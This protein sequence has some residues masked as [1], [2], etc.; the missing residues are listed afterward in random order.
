MDADA[1]AQI[2]NVPQPAA[3]HAGNGV[4]H[5]LKSA[6]WSNGTLHVAVVALSIF[7]IIYLAAYVRSS[8]LSSPTVLDY[9]PWWFFRQAQRIVENGMVMPPWDEQSFFPPGRPSDFFN[10]WA[11]HMAIMY[12]VANAING[13]DLTT[14][15]KW[16]PMIVAAAA[17]IPAFLLGKLIK[18]DLQG[19]VT[20]LFVVLSPGLI[21]VSMA[22]YC[23]TD[24]IVAFYTMA[25]TFSLLLAISKKPDVKS[26]PYFLLAIIINLIFVFTWGYGWIIQMFFILLVPGLAMFRVVEQA[27]HNRSL[28]FDFKSIYDEAVSIAIP[29]AIVLIPVNVIGTLLNLQNVFATILNG[30]TFF[31]GNALIVNISVAEL[32]I[33]NPFSLEGITTIAERIGLQAVTLLAFAAMFGYIVIRKMLKSEKISMVEIYLF[34][35]IFIT[36]VL[37]TRGVRF[38]LLFGSAAA[39]T[40]GY[41]AGNLPGMLGNKV[42][43]ATFFGF[44]ILV[45]VMLVSTAISTGSQGSGMMISQ[46]WY[47]MLDWFKANAS[48]KSLLVTWWDPGHILTGYTGLRAM[49]DGAHCPS[50]V[51]GCEPYS[52]NDRIQ[53]MGRAFSVSDEN[54][55]VSILRKYRQLTSAQCEAD[56]QL[57]SGRGFPA[58]ACD[59]VSDMYVIASS[60]LIG[61]YYWL[62]YFGTGTGRNFLQLGLSNYDSAQGILT[63]GSGEISLVF[64]DNKWVPVIN[65]PTQGIRNV[66]VRDVVY[67][68]NNKEVRA[69]FND[70]QAIDGMVYV[71]PSFRAALFMDSSVRDSVFT[72]MFFFNGEG[73]SNYKLVYSNP[74]IRVFKVVF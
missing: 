35:W 63:Y 55:S 12:K 11:Y 45:S 8:T 70:T 2:E 61:K 36:F 59:P 37:I 71:D 29:L 15:A 72:R 1:N 53:D 4:S 41:V 10:G 22:G 30:L 66:V 31:G 46:N 40:I 64:R 38:S 16:A 3:S 6:F 49:A 28:K 57:F 44:L 65:Y 24:M 62:S 21:G 34:L 32:Q 25:S 68:E 23:D 69:R 20:A 60:D 43:K 54:E 19:I 67:F 26:V 48:S 47:D 7:A 56:R 42:L 13:V 17:V 51:N 52:H 58:D 18:N 27:I 14:V 39:A 9:D 73:L 74:E 33:I 50:G 5:R